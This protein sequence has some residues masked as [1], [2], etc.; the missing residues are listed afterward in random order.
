MW[1][2]HS[3]REG[4][5]ATI[6]IVVLDESGSAAALCPLPRGISEVVREPNKRSRSD[7]RRTPVELPSSDGQDS[8]RSSIHERNFEA[9]Y[10]SHSSYLLFRRYLLL[11]AIRGELCSIARELPPTSAQSG[12]EVHRCLQAGK[13][14]LSERVS[15]PEEGLLPGAH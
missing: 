12:I 6:T 13:S 7:A 14:R 3:A 5:Y 9:G 8:S 15:R 11:H 4:E 10:V 2:A 1:C